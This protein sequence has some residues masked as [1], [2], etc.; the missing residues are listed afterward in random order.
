MGLNVKH[1]NRYSFLFHVLHPINLPDIQIFY[2][3]KENPKHFL[4]IWTLALELEHQTATDVL[5]I[6]YTKGLNASKR[7]LTRFRLKSFI[8]K[9]GCH[10]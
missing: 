6:E 7:F 9:K 5:T 1:L 8:S 3:P 4:N 10:F 2:N